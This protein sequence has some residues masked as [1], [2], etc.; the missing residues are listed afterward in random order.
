MT[1][2]R[3]FAR[4]SVRFGVGATQSRTQP[5]Q[6]RSPAVWPWASERSLSFLIYKMG[7]PGLPAAGTK[8]GSPQGLLN[9][10]MKA[11]PAAHLVTW[12]RET[13]LPAEVASWKL[14]APLVSMAMM[15]TSPQPTSCS[16]WT[17]PHRSPPPPTDSA[18]AP[19]FAPSVSF[20]SFTM[21][22]WPSL[23]GGGGR[24]VRAA[25]PR[26]R[27]AGLPERP[28]APP[29]ALTPSTDGPRG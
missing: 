12:A 13:S 10:P 11:P 6:Y 19:G 4:G 26:R 14:W 7:H 29:S 18:M 2:D 20:S 23:G 1:S 15:G 17:T 28:P 21:E 8:G 27:Q 9:P 3:L 5:Q 16:P 22:V 24:Q 25:L